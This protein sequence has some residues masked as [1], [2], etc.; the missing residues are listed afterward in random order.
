M[1]H[2][3]TFVDFA[4]VFRPKK[5]QEQTKVIDR[6]LGLLFHYIDLLLMDDSDKY[7]FTIEAHL[8]SEHLK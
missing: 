2:V 1:L 8:I 4:Y 3:P 6:I 7:N 5:F